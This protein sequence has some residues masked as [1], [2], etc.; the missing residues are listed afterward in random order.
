MML[1]TQGGTLWV[2]VQTAG[3]KSNDLE[4]YE[5][6]LVR[7]HGCLFAVLN[8]ATRQVEPGHVRIFANRIIVDAPA[9]ADLF[10]VP[11]KSD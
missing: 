2:D 1:H 5:N 3:T 7:L 4:S 8:T 9:P 6:A 11:K 10:S